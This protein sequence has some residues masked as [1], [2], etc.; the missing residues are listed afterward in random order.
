MQGTDQHADGHRIA[1]PAPGLWGA[2]QAPTHSAWNPSPPHSPCLQCMHFMHHDS[3][4]WK[5]LLNAIMPWTTLYSSRICTYSTHA[6]LYIYIYIHITY[7]TTHIASLCMS[8]QRTMAALIMHV[9]RRPCSTHARGAAVRTITA[10]F[11]VKSW[12][13]TRRVHGNLI[14]NALPNAPG[15]IYSGQ[16]Q[17]HHFI[18]GLYHPACNV[19]DMKCMQC[20]RRGMHAVWKT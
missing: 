20:K 17:W 2:P 16:S 13:H 6:D 18:F 15:C 3:G 1:G 9:H 4:C 11:R 14:L 7:P 8:M 19:E 10:V 5:W 12:S